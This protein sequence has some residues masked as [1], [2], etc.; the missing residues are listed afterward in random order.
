VKRIKNRLAS[1]LKWI[2]GIPI[3][4]LFTPFILVISAI[5]YFRRKKFQKNYAE[6]LKQHNGKNY[7]CYNNRKNSKKYIENEIIPNFTG[8]IEIVYLNGKKIESE[9]HVEFISRALF[10]LK[11]Y[12]R[13]PHLMKIRDGKL[14][15]KSVN[16]V[17]Y[18]VLNLNKPK[19]ELVSQIN[20][21]FELTEN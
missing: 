4:V 8:E 1:I 17:F 6:F 14:I 16:N 18:N 15:D 2:I 13:F 5:H 21:F 20:R 10:K 3:L 11:N 12:S 7:F 19:D 9:H